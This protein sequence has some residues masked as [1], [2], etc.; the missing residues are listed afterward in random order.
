MEL[1]YTKGKK[2][3]KDRILQVTTT[4]NEWFS[5][6]KL[7]LLTNQLEVNELEINGDK[8]KRTGNFFFSNALKEALEMA[9]LGIDWALPENKP[10]VEKWCKKWMIKF[11]AIEP[12]LNRC[13]K[14]K[15]D[16]FK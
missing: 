13:W 16:E 9:E 12:Q 3:D 6:F 8:I 10:T 7:A 2:G 5:I 1:S 15:G 14:N 11:E 4:E